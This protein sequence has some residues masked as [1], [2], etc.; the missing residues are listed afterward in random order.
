MEASNAHLNH[1]LLLDA[2]YLLL[3]NQVFAAIVRKDDHKG[4]R[5][6]LES[7]FLVFK[8]QFLYDNFSSVGWGCGGYGGSGH[9]LTLSRKGL[10][11]SLSILPCPQGSIS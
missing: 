7:N 3:K 1:L 11:L 2:N 10:I 6:G 9:S 4:L 5:R 8:K